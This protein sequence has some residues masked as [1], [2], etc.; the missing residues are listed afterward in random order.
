MLS[1]ELLPLLSRSAS[2]EDDGVPRGRVIWTSSI[3]AVRRRFDIADFQGFTRPEAYESAKRLTDI[4]A[5]TYS[6][7][8]VRQYSTPFLSFDSRIDSVDNAVAKQRELP[9]P[10]K[11]YLTH[12]GVV[13]S[14]LFPVPWF[15][16]WAY[17]LALVISRWLGSAWHNIEGYRG[18]KSAVWVTME[19]QSALNDARADRIKWGS[20]TDHALRTDVKITEVEGW[21]WEGKVEDPNDDAEPGIFRKTVGRK[22]GVVD[23]TESGIIEFEETGAEIWKEMERLRLLWSDIIDDKLE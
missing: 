17:E 22:L 3:E 8:S 7:P 16:L 10:P 4:L 2:H 1:H 18:A 6:L 13:V 12:P 20:A 15:L 23:A 9:V 14:A 21:G 11:I 19:Q 5:L